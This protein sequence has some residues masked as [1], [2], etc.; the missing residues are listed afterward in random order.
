MLHPADAS[1]SR[2]TVRTIALRAGVSSATVS[3]AL[4][5]HPLISA[6]TRKRVLSVAQELGYRPDPNV[7]KLMHHLRTR[8]PPGF[9]S[10]LVALTTVREADEQSYIREIIR[11]ARERAESFGYSLSVVRIEDSEAPRRDLERM[12]R[13]RGVEGIL[14]LPMQTPR[15]FRHLLD[16]S[17]FSIVAATHGVLAPEF[18]R[19]VP[20]QF[21][22]TLA[23]C[24]ELTRRQYQRL[25][26]VLNSRHDLAVGHGS[27]AAVVWQ[28]M[29]G[30]AESVM[31]LVFNGAEPTELKRW[32]ARQ[33][34]DAII[35][36]GPPDAV[37]IARALG[38]RIPGPVGFATTNRSGTKF[39]GIEERPAE[40]GAT[41][42]RLLTSLIQHGEK[43][44]PEVPTVTMVKGEWIDGRSVRRVARK[45]RV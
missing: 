26:L 17:K 2:P 4:R 30:G 44:I 31:P 3:L 41:A 1:G 37:A 34:P 8:R 23:L 25:G 40:I 21:S 29:L 12:L 22:N 27:S 18:H 36:S 7:A 13:A 35:A 24:E 19:V 6:A 39:A 43:G 38:L 28:N 20:H 11:S 14:L 42:V 9:Q 32:F 16:W 15:S 10:M 45:S 5:G 33:R